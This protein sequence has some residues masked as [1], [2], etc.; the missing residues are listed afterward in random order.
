MFGLF[1]AIAEWFTGLLVDGIMSNFTRMF[2]E[3]NRAVGEIS[4]Q[5]GQTPEGWNSGIFALIRT[6]SQTVVMPIAGMILTFILCYELIHMVIEKNN[7]ADSVC[8]K[9]RLLNATL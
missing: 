5:V 2:N 8:C 6:L 7:M 3:V 9:G 4:S 1:D